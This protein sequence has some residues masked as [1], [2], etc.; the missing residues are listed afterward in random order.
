M[1]KTKRRIS[2]EN[3]YS[4]TDRFFFMLSD[5]KTTIK[6]NKTII[7]FL[8]LLSCVQLFSV[9]FEDFFIFEF[10]SNL[11][12]FI[13]LL[14]LDL[15]H[16]VS[17]GLIVS[18]ILFGFSFLYLLLVLFQLLMPI[19]RRFINVNR[20]IGMSFIGYFSIFSF[21]VLNN[22]EYILLSEFFR[23]KISVSGFIIRLVPVALNLLII[24]TFNMIFTHFLF[25][26]NFRLGDSILNND[27]GWSY[28]YFI[29]KLLIYILHFLAQLG[30][31]SKQIYGVCI[32]VTL[33]LYAL[34]IMIYYT[35]DFNKTTSY[36]IE[37]V[38][39]NVTIV[40]VLFA[41]IA[42][43]MNLLSKDILYF[44][45][46]VLLS[47][48]CTFMLLKLRAKSFYVRLTS[49][50]NL[51]AE[52]K[53]NRFVALFDT[54]LFGLMKRHFDKDFNK[55][56]EYIDNFIAEA[57][58]DDPVHK[59]HYKH[60]VLVNVSYYIEKNYIKEFH[61]DVLYML[62]SIKLETE[63]INYKMIAELLNILESTK[64]MK[65]MY[66]I[67]EALRELQANIRKH[68]T[69]I[70]NGSEF[71]E[72]NIIKYSAESSRLRM[73]LLEYISLEVKIIESLAKSDKTLKSSELVFG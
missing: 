37:F 41:K 26:D 1:Q 16:I 45:L 44:L 24:I 34:Q 38:K 70:Q 69:E 22:L 64:N 47:S 56:L 61:F 12:Y 9:I 5:M 25:R 51:T 17:D 7:A 39:V 46:T 43:L 15:A 18:Y 58:K 19:K 8:M 29:N 67:I 36:K 21:V 14:K 4:V 28:F 3:A 62:M 30:V 11:K 53:V 55:Y 27:Q 32:G 57:N 68:T 2:D 40:Y 20:F 48:F 66:L 52:I 72:K 65:E 59:T 13:A 49:R 35:N 50:I 33:V 71:S 23:G 42:V 31:V 60:S 63:K 73:Y 6:D 54:L 10:N